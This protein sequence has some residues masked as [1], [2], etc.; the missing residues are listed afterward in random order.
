VEELSEDNHK[1]I[2][3]H[4]Q[5]VYMVVNN[6]LIGSEQEVNQKYLQTIQFNKLIE[7]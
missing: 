4:D 7:M 5:E 3:S 1:A 2:I 6:D